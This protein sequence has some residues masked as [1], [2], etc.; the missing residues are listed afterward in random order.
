MF[1]I[2]KS[3]CFSAAKMCYSTAGFHIYMAF[4]D[5]FIWNYEFTVQFNGV[6]YLKLAVMHNNKQV[7]NSYR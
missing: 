5:V 6:F 7:V 1:V 2:F 4:H 3:Y